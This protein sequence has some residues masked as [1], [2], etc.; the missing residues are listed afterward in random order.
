MGENGAM[1]GSKYCDTGKKKRGGETHSGQEKELSRMSRGS[2]KGR[3]TQGRVRKTAGS[4][5]WKVG[6][7]LSGQAWLGRQ[8]RHTFI[9]LMRILKSRTAMFQYSSFSSWTWR[10]A[11]TGLWVTAKYL[12]YP[13]TNTICPLSLLKRCGNSVLISRFTYTV[14]TS[15]YLT[16]NQ[17]LLA[18]GSLGSPCLPQL[19]LGGCQDP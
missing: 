10:Q 9:R 11:N 2:Q 14:T 6:A 5:L 16:E 4:W 12:H 19:W 17:L 8:V 1:T 3:N 18:S 7:L 13:S 15:E